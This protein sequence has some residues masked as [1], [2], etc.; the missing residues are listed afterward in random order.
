MPLGATVGDVMLLEEYGGVVLPRGDSGVMP[1][2]GGGRAMPLHG[3]DGAMLS[4]RGE[5]AR[6]RQ[7]WRDV[8]I[9]MES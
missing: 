7:R 8:I 9:M 2:R 6:C 4:S 1:S 3:D 5:P